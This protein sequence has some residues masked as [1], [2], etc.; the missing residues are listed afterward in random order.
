MS[1]TS[2]W[3]SDLAAWGIP[4]EIIDQAP[5]SPWIHPSAL[6]TVPEVISETLSHARARELMPENGSVLDIGCGGGIAAFAVAPPAKKVIGVD[7][8]QEMLDMFAQTANDRNLQHEE[9]LGDWPDVASLV[10][11]ADVVTCHHVVF[12]ISDIEPFVREL[13]SHAQRR[14]VIEMPQHHPLSSMSQAWK[15]FWNLD[16]PV[17]PTSKDFVTLLK[18]FGIDAHHEDWSHSVRSGISEEQ[19]ARFMRI[20]LCLPESRETEV[21]DFFREHPVPANR[22]LTTIW[23]DK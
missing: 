12:N 18:S 6:F 22:N 4:S 20:R 14:V 11:A 13:D 8:Q 23:W 7:H 1:L 15:H 9:F 19:N 2:N 17:N 21:R 16:R 5:Q 10:P 3:S